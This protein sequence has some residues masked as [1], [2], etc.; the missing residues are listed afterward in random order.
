MGAV[1][2]DSTAGKACYALFSCVIPILF[3]PFQLSYQFMCQAGMLRISAFLFLALSEIQL[4]L[5]V[6]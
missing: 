4:H 5:S 2:C 6:L 1:H 3:P